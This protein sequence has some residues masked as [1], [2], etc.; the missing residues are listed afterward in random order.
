MSDTSIG[1]I[2]LIGW[3][4]MGSAIGGRLLRQG[5]DLLTYD[6]SAPARERAAAAG[7][8]VASSCQDVVA[9]VETFIT[10]LP[11]DRTVLAAFEAEN[12][13]A[14]GLREGQLWIEM[15]S[16]FP[17][18]TARLAREIGR[19]GAELLDA[20]ITGGVGKAAIGDLTAIA[21]GPAATL[22]R[23]RSILEHVAS[24]ICHVSEQPGA[25]DLVKTVNNMLSAA[26]LAV[27]GE[28]L[29]LAEA[30]GVEAEALIDVLNSGTGQSNATSWKIPRYV[31]SAGFDSGIALGQYTKDLDIAMRSCAE[32]GI[33]LSIVPHV[34][35]L[36]QRYSDEGH[37]ASD[38]TYAVELVRRGA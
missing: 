13:I 35:A 2:G 20:P 37:A 38:H 11:D 8:D 15:S 5:A 10:L 25:G 1:A 22:E 33:E 28:G 32:L 17:A 4:Q 29:R 26:N 27:A 23:G 18:A 36:W 30:A 14:A 19:F 24:R 6:R 16:S 3:G 21:A 7:A 12:G 34:Q 31:L 9:T